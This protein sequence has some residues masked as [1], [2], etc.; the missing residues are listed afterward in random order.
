MQVRTVNLASKH[1]IQVT[2]PHADAGGGVR[3]PLAGHEIAG[4]GVMGRAKQGRF[5]LGYPHRH[6]SAAREERGCC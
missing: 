2:V 5:L 1:P 6:R 3:P 4:R